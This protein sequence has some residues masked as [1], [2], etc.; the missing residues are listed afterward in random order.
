MNA[1]IV[2]SNPLGEANAQL[3]LSGR[4]SLSESE[5]PRLPFKRLLEEQLL[6][7]FAFQ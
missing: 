6:R 5:C 2:G 7:S 3:K 1:S 4:R